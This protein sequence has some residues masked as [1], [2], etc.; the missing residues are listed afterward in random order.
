MAQAGRLPNSRSDAEAVSVDLCE[1]SFGEHKTQ[2]RRQL[3]TV[4]DFTIKPMFNINTVTSFCSLLL[5]LLVSAA[6]EMEHPGR[7]S[8]LRPRPRSNSPY[9]SSTMTEECSH[10]MGRSLH[11][12]EAEQERYPS[13]HGKGSCWRFDLHHVVEDQSPLLRSPSKSPS[14]RTILGSRSI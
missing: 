6:A 4:L 1:R 11:R 13:P 3:V 8:M 5:L 14:Q 7:S 9:S 12:K 10:R 2:L